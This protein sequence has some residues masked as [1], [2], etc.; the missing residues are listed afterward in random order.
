[1]AFPENLRRLRTDRYLTQ[2]GLAKEAGLSRV[3]ITR[4]E[5]GETP[6]LART[7]R[8]LAK[9]LGVE[10]RELAMPN[11]LAAKSAA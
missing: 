10:P 9:A 8:Q 1:M 6:P 2:D 4:L 11:E 5:S 7:V 3:T